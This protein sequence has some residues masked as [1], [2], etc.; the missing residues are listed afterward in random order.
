[1]QY[2]LYT[3]LRSTDPLPG[4]LYLYSAACTRGGEEAVEEVGT[5]REEVETV[6]VTLG[7]TQAVRLAGGKVG[8]QT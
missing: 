7:V 8:N 5:V 1:M 3:Q 6:E 4:C 2:S